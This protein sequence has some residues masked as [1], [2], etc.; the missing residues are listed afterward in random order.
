VKLR[1]GDV[2]II[3]VE[4]IFKAMKDRERESEPQ[5]KDG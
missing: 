3:Y 4:F 1:E 2:Y 5:V